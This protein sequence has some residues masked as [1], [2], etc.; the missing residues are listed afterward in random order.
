MK[1]VKYVVL[2]LILLQFFI[3][4]LVPMRE[5]YHYRIDYDLTIAEPNNVD[6][7]LDQISREISSNPEDEYI[8]MLGDS[9]FYGSPGNSDQSPNAFMEQRALQD[10]ETHIKKVYNLS[11]P[12]MQ[13][14]DLYTMLLKLDEHG[15]STD[16]LIFNI[17]Y[18]SF[19]PREPWPPVVFWM[20]KQ[21]KSTDPEVFAHV[22]PQLEASKYMLPDT[23]YE[24]YKSIIYDELLH[25]IPIYT[26]K[27]FLQKS[28]EHL[29]L[30]WKGEPVPDDALGDPRPWYVKEGLKTYLESDEIVNSYT[31]Q[32]FDFSENSLDVFFLDQI[33][34]H[35]QGKDTLVVMTGI[36]QELME[37]HVTKQGYKD[38]MEQIDRYFEDK[39]VRYIN[40]EGRM[41]DALFSDHT[42][43]TPEGYEELGN[44]LWETYTK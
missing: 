31:D 44:L 29:K 7:A 21:L 37:H 28:W 36:N 19:M 18:P 33:L 8:V 23:L 26:Y 2:Y 39:Q 30:S 32:P 17:R 38:N 6:A 1:A 16:K 27:D 20:Q 15:I 43:F 13:L 3:P 40:L 35:Q 14:G 22:R 5:V 34:E 10:T 9:V 12:A 11:L 25:R 42:H 24:K 4:Y 41:D